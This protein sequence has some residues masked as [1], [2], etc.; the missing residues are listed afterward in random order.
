VSKLVNQF[1]SKD[2]TTK[3]AMDNEISLRQQQRFQKGY[4][5]EEYVYLGHTENKRTSKI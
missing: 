1:D 5:E 2:V 3:H 4:L